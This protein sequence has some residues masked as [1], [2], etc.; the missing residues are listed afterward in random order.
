MVSVMNESTTFLILIA[1]VILAVIG[2]LLMSVENFIFIYK[3]SRQQAELDYARDHAVFAG[4]ENQRNT[5]I[6][7]RRRKIV[8]RKIVMTLG[9]IL[10]I[11]GIS[12]QIIGTYYSISNSGC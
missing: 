11:L 9:F 1:G 7:R 8:L 2:A 4:D 10:L 3:N 6:E 12:L 5:D